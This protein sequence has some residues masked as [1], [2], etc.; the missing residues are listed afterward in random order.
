MPPFVGYEPDFSRSMLANLI[1]QAT[2]R[3]LP[4]QD[5]LDI[6]MAVMTPLEETG[7]VSL[8]E[9]STILP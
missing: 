9:P 4:N 6:D 8:I 7:M 2:G 1:H 5:I 3:R